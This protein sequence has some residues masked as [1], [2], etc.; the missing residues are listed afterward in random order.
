MP[1]TAQPS[2]NHPKLL[3][4]ILIA[5]CAPQLAV[6]TVYPWLCHATTLYLDLWIFFLFGF[7]LVYQFVGR[8][9]DQIVII[10]TFFDGFTILIPCLLFFF[11][12][13][14]PAH[15]LRL[16]S[17][18][19]YMDT[20]WVL[21]QANWIFD[22]A[23]GFRYLSYWPQQSIEQSIHAIA[24]LL[25]F[26]LIIH[27]VR[28]RFQLSVILYCLPVSL[29]IGTLSGCLFFYDW[30]EKQSF[31]SINH[32]MA[33]MLTILIPLCLGALLTFYKKTRK[34]VFKT[35]AYSLKVSLKNVIQGE[36]AILT[37]LTLVFF[38]LFGFILF[39][40][41]L[42]LKMLGLSFALILGGLLLTGKPKLRSQFLVWSLIG[43]AMGIYALNSNQISMSHQLNSLLIEILKKYPLTGVGPGALPVVLSNYIDT[44]LSVQLYQTS[45]WLIFL[46][47]YG[48]LGVIVW[49]A[50][51]IVFF[52]RMNNTWQKRQSL[53]NVGWGLGI[54]TA[55]TATIFLGLG[56]NFGNAFIT[57][58]A[59]SFIAACGFLVLYAGHHSSRQTFFY[60]S[61][62][63]KRTS[64]NSFAVAGVILIFL[65]IGIFQLILSIATNHTVLNQFQART[66]REAIQTIKANILNARLWHQMAKWYVQNSKDAVSYI[67]T[68]LPKSDICYEISCYL[69]PNNKNI[70][71]DSA[72]YWVWRSQTLNDEQSTPLN[73]NNEIPQTRN[74]A[75]S[76]FQKKFRK[77]LNQQPDQYKSVVDVIWQWYRDDM[78]VLGAIPEKP[79]SLKQAA[80]EYVLLQKND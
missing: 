13:P 71:F 35:F 4:F 18:K 46:V 36:Q 41:P 45:A 59:L 67:Q 24:C 21:I 23:D 56:Y 47:E 8:S 80:L 52:I 65:C 74:Q 1:P 61:I 34:P 49:S 31:L 32:Q 6:F 2:R 79:A 20:K 19:L 17:S 33:L 12:L 57:M 38:L 73:N 64:L 5:L 25:S 50:A 22:S 3:L 40:R 14:L 55:L 7:W 28:N 70:G 42:G 30:S 11:C 15:V 9:N 48:I 63:I 58:P 60:R 77:I 78:I 16:L 10:K 51:M 26:F 53:F 29:L 66:E 44:D 27:T 72:R 62:K 37:R 43:L 68:N 69:A 39:A 54:M 76:I 75:I